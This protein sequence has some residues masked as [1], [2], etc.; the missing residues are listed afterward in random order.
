MK[1]INM[2]IF[3][4]I[5]LHIKQVLF[6]CDVNAQQQEKLGRNILNRICERW[7]GLSRMFNDTVSVKYKS[8]R[9]RFHGL[10]RTFYQLQPGR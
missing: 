1:I 5:S 10:T 3:L 9:R 4:R 2:V 8:L 7:R 6:V